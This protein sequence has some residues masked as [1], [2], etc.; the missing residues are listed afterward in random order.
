MKKMQ[1]RVRDFERERQ[2][3]I[4]GEE[5]NG[6]RGKE[7]ERLRCRGRE[8]K[9]R[10]AFPPASPRDGIS[11]ARE[12]ERGEKRDTGEKKEEKRNPEGQRREGEKEKIR[13]KYKFHIA[14]VL[15]PGSYRM[16]D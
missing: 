3:E 9:E 10:E 2:R 7:R 14:C 15:P 4:A 8:K 12:R 13:N 5:E 1:E 16:N 6:E 11:V